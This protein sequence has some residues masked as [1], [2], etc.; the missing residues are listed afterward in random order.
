MSLS[1]RN[2]CENVESGA[3]QNCA[4]LV[5]LKNCYKNEYLLSE[6][7]FDT[8][9]NEPSKVMFLHFLINQILKHRHI[10]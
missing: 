1:I 8:A 4:T 7:A 5:D 3:V 10:I 2:F 6:V 9:E